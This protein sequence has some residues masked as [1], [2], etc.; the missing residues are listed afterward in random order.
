MTTAHRLPDA[1]DPHAS[2]SRYEEMWRRT[3]LAFIPIGALA[4]FVGW[5][6]EV[7][8]AQATSFDLVLYPVMGAVL[9]ALEAVLA[10]G[11][12]TLPLVVLSIIV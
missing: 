6:L 4:F 3:L 12:R 5:A 2:G 8:S 1:T 7:P 9:L 11:R 10:F